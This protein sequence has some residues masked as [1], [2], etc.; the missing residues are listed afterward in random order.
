MNNPSSRAFVLARCPVTSSVKQSPSWDA[1]W[2]GNSLA[3][4]W[5]PA[6]HCRVHT[7]TPGPYVSQ[8]NL[9]H[10]FTSTTNPSHLI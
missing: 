7:G 6:Y 5:Y 2:P 9:A 8:M 4:F 1:E 3:F 10:T